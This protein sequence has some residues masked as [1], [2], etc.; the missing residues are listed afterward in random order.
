MVP[1]SQALADGGLQMAYKCYEEIKAHKTEEFYF[2]EDD[3]IGLVYQVQSLKKF[4]RAIEV[5][6]LNIHAFPEYLESYTRLAG[7][8]LQNGDPVQ[9]E[10]CLVKALSIQPDHAPAI[11]LLDNIRLMRSA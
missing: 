5:L 6:E 2:D 9:A 10:K 7:I 1:I 8:H 3:M 4:G 11:E